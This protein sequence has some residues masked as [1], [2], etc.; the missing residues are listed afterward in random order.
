MTGTLVDAFGSPRLATGE[1]KT[2][3]NDEQSRRI[4]P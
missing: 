1:E 3:S 4:K 2:K